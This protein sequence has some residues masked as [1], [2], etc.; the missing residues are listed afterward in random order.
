MLKLSKRKNNLPKKIKKNTKKLKPEFQE[1]LHGRRTA[2]SLLSFG[3]GTVLIGNF[4][5]S[6]FSKYIGGY[7]TFILGIL[8]FV[9]GGILSREFRK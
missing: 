5:W 7:T 2:L 8:L 3:V 1:M 9:V 4:I 6:S